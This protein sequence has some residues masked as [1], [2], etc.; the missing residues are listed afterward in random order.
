MIP[1][2]GC[3]KKINN[4]IYNKQ[5]HNTNM[6]SQRDSAQDSRV[7]MSRNDF[8]MSTAS[9]SALIFSK[10]EQ[11]LDNSFVFDYKGFCLQLNSISSLFLM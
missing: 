7:L 4:Q 2:T 3:V 11:D 6:P 9:A 10:N 1:V 8:E 5:R